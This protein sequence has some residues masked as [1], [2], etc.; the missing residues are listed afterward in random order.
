MKPEEL[1]IYQLWGLDYSYLVYLFVFFFF[2][3]VV[4]FHSFLFVSRTDK[5]MCLF[6]A[7]VIVFL[8]IKFFL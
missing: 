3:P 5:W 8:K 1:E 7:D 4:F 2:L 6:P